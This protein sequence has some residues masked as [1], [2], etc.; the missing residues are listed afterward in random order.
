MGLYSPHWV[1]DRFMK[2]LNDSLGPG[3]ILVALPGDNSILGDPDG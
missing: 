2:R 1:S 3:S